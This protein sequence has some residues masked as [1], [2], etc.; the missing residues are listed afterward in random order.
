MTKEKLAPLIS[1]VGS[2][3]RAELNKMAKNK[4]NPFGLKPQTIKDFGSGHA[5]GMRTMVNALRAAGALVVEE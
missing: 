1:T 4:D 5:D 2:E 3:Y